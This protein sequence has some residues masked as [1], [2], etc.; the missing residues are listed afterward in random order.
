MCICFE[1]IVREISVFRGWVCDVTSVR[2]VVCEACECDVV[3]V[4]RCRLMICISSKVCCESFSW[5][6]TPLTPDAMGGLFGSRKYFVKISEPSPEHSNTSNTESFSLLSDRA[7]QT[8][9]I[10]ERDLVAL[11]DHSTSEVRGCFHRSSN[12][13]TRWVLTS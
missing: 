2:D 3:L 6:E 1:I 13:K 11:E 9:R 10:V 8:Y 5:K 12:N 4:H 7:S